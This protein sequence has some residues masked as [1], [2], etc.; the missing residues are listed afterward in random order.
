MI[1]PLCLEN[2]NHRY[3]ADKIRE[4]YLCSS[5][6]LLF[7]PREEL[8]SSEAEKERYDLHDNLEN[9]EGYVLYLKKIADSFLPY[10][11]EGWGGLD[12]GSGKTKKLASLL[13]FPVE[14]FDLYYHNDQELL[15]KK[16]DFIVLSEVI[17]H[18]REPRETML[19]LNRILREEGMFFI[20]TKLRPE[21]ENVFSNWFYKRDVTHIEF[22]SMKALEYLGKMLNRPHV[23]R[24]GEDLFRLSNH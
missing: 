23:E 14:S 12:F 6:D 2:N 16:Y 9:D 21:K 11:K 1:C 17:E 18:L 13:P 22:F 5:C 24:I 10:L 15:K 4:Y 20:K 7:V 19:G 3:S 8:I